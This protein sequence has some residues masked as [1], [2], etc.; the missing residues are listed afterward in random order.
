MATS[1]DNTGCVAAENTDND[2]FFC[3]AKTDDLTQAFKSAALALTPAAASLLRGGSRSRRECRG[4]ER[5]RL[6]PRIAAVVGHRH[7]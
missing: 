4:A 7:K 1:S 5:V 3:Q 6:Q 2:H